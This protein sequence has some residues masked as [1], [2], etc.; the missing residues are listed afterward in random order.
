MKETNDLYS[1]GIH[2]IIAMSIVHITLKKKMTQ[3]AT[4]NRTPVM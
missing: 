2:T 4:Q 3:K 1:V